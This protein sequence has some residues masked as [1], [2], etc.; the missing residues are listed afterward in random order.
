MQA[1]DI[2]SRMLFVGLPILGLVEYQA[3]LSYMGMQTFKGLLANVKSPTFDNSSHSKSL[4][5]SFHLVGNLMENILKCT[6]FN[7]EIFSG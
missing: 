7:K 1:C 6:D 3:T 4:T 2:S 5:S